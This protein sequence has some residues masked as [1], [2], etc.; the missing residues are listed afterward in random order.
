MPLPPMALP[1]FNGWDKMAHFIMFG[2]LAICFVY[3][4]RRMKHRSIT[5]LEVAVIIA[6]VTLLGGAIELL[7]GTELINRSCDLSD[8]IANAAGAVTFGFL[9]FFYNKKSQPK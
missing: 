9:G 2:G 3:D 7:Q 4:T 6:C 8:F 5:L 1:E